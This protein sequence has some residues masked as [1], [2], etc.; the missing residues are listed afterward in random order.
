MQIKKILKKIS[1]GISLTKDY[2]V[3]D[4]IGLH[5]CVAY[6]VY[7]ISVKWHH[8]IAISGVL[9]GIFMMEVFDRY[10]NKGIFSYKD[11]IAGL[12]GLALAYFINT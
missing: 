6:I 11:I 4:N 12:L 5:F 8:L 9:L 10:V 7:D 3:K 1:V 2:L